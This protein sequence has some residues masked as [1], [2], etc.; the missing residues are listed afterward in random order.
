MRTKQTLPMTVD[1]LLLLAKEPSRSSVMIM[2]TEDRP[3]DTCGQ[4][5]IRLCPTMSKICH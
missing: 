4:R 3:S 1:K 2:Q 5:E